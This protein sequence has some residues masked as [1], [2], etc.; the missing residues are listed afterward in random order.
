[1]FRA[2]F[3]IKKQSLKTALQ[4]PANLLLNLFGVALNGFA[5]V[6]VILLLT[7][8]F[9]GIGGWS[10]W[11]V[12]FMAGLWRLSHA[13]HHTL[14]MGF[15]EHSSLVHDGG[16]DTLLVRPA[17]PIVQIIAGDLPLSAIGELLPA[18]ALFAMTAG[19]IAVPWS[20]GNIA[21]LVVVIV[22]GAVIEWAMYLCFSALDFWFPE[23]EGGWSWIP[24]TFLFPTARY[25]LHIY[26]RIFLTVFTFVFPFGFMAYYPAHHFLGILPTGLP[27]FFIYFSPLVALVLLAVGFGFWSLGLRHYQ[28]TGA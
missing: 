19:H 25:P 6:L 23:L 9:Q 17:H 11:Q 4:Y 22:S 1:M 12:G 5:E 27:A 7:T 21:F 15:S 14:F 16:Y 10:F 3:L 28:S 18:A 20:L 13:L 26:G 24:D 8:A 2:F